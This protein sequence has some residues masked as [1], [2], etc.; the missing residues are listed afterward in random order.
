MHSTPFASSPEWQNSASRA[1]TNGGKAPTPNYLEESFVADDNAEFWF[2][3]TP[4]GALKTVDRG[5]LEACLRKGEIPPVAFV[6][7]SGWGEWLRA[8]EVTEL[9][10]A[11]SP[12]ARLSARTPKLSP[13][14]THPPPVPKSNGLH[15]EPIVPVASSPENDKPGT[16]LLEPEELSFTDLDA[17]VEPVR[18]KTPPPPSMRGKTT[19]VAPRPPSRMKASP[20]LQPKVKAGD[21][22]APPSAP[23]TASWVEVAAPVI[24]EK[25]EPVVPV[26]TS[27]IHAPPA[28]DKKKA[29]LSD[30]EAAL[31]PPPARP[32]P[33]SVAEDLPTQD[34]NILVM[35]ESERD[36]PTIMRDAIVPV[37][38]PE[39]EAPTQVQA[40]PLHEALPSWSDEVDAQLAQPGH[41]V[42]PAITAPTPAPPQYGSMTP[43]ASYDDSESIPPKKS[44]SAGLIVG[45]LLA[46][47]FL[48]GGTLAAGGYYFWGRSAASDDAAKQAAAT[49]AT[50]APAV[51]PEPVTSTVA[52]QMKKAGVKLADS[53]AVS[54]PPYV[55]SVP[56]AESVAIGFAATA[57][58]AV[59]LTVT[60]S[61]DATR[62]FERTETRNITGVVPL[63]AAG[64]LSFTVDREGGALRVPRTVDHASPFVLGM[65]AD[66][67][68]RATEGKEP[69]TLWPE[70]AGQKIT[71][72]RVASV[73]DVGHVLTFRQGTDVKVGWVTPE[74]S[75]KTPLETVAAGGMRVGTPNIAVNET[76]T[77][78]TF[79]ARPNDTAPWTVRL[80]KAAHGELP[81]AS[82]TFSLP[83]GGPGQEAI[84][85]TAV[86]LPGRRWLLQWTE[87]PAGKRQVRAQTLSHELSPIGD[88]VTVSPA[89]TEAGQGVIAV[90][91]SQAAAAFYLVRAQAGYELWATGLDCK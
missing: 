63:I 26:K 73:A 88:P 89:G 12:A 56:G 10:R 36:G 28:E 46:V 9:A 90:A 76:D 52:C 60:P 23:P 65:A 47:L 59:G 42:L 18:A 34:E 20:I 31:P 57:T 19:S 79:A 55:A 39:N 71:E 49:A 22:P 86:G 85:P 33:P 41:A 35:P 61:L 13:D 67:Y 58:S 30:L 14:A 78:V 8:A 25:P 11:I 1:P 74:G 4:D 72:T 29:T 45:G 68:A 81:R 40:S 91:S 6:W 53:I 66:G 87:G 15:L 21:A 69:E 77:L 48:G 54:V 7:R 70:G 2:W 75:K 83:E 38:D 3:A 37:S 16:Q 17:V 64:S 27:P 84:A 43:Q 82:T 44:S 5:E 50:A 32:T 51:P 62:S 80:A 24:V